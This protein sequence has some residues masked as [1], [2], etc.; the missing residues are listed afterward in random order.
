MHA[1]H[2]IKVARIRTE[3]TGIVSLELVPVDA[4]RPLPPA[5]SGSHVDLLL[6]DGLHRSY[7]L[8]RPSDGSAYGIAVQREAAGRGGSRHVHDRI[9]EGDELTISAPRNHFALRAGRGNSVLVAGGIGITPI[10]AMLQTLAARGEQVRLIYCA[11][12]RE[13]AAFLRE[14]EALANAKAARVET[15]FDDA[16]GP[17]D[18]RKLLAGGDPDANYYC[19][20]P[21]GMLDAFEKACSALGCKNS[22]IERFGAETPSPAARDA[23]YEV[24]LAR[25]GRHLTVHAGQSLLDVL[26]KAGI[27]VAYSCQEGA[28][29]SCET[30]VLAGDIDHRDCLLSAEERAAG[31]TMLV[32][33]SGCRSARLVLDL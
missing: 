9:R 29:G 20:G 17:P 4:A 24:E 25:S 5:D 26:L 1:T 8:Y 14:I 28:C 19:C 3:A 2:Q 16:A 12:S 6:A 21:A 31:N 22:F 18:L 27:D 10:Y 7:S 15:C 23:D 32:C 33:V 13:H 11:R 30:A